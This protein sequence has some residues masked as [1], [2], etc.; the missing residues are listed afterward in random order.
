MSKGLGFGRAMVRAAISSLLCL[1]LTANVAIAT[2]VVE[3]SGETTPAKLAGTSTAAS[4]VRKTADKVADEVIVRFKSGIGASSMRSTM[5]G[6]GLEV[7]SQSKS[8]AAVVRIPNGVTP[9]Q[10]AARLERLSSVSFAEPNY[11]ARKTGAPNDSLYAEQWGLKQM[12]LETAWASSK[13]DGVVVAVVDTGVDYTHPDLNG[14]VLEGWDFVNDDADPIDDDGHGTHV[15]GIIA[16]ATDD[17]TG[18]AG[19]GW[20][21]KVLPVKVLDSSGSGTYADIAEGI[22]YAADNGAKIIN[23]SLGG[24]AS[25]QVLEDAVVYARSKGAL[26]LA[27]AGNSNSSSPS[28]PAAI[29]GVVSVAA[30]KNTTAYE[31]SGAA[32][33]GTW[34]YWSS[35]SNSGGSLYWSETVGSSMTWTITGTAFTMIGFLDSISAKGNVYVDGNLVGQADFSSAN[36]GY[37]SSNVYQ[38]PVFRQTGLTPGSHTVKIEVAVQGDD[39]NPDALLVEQGIE[40]RAT[41]S[42][43]GKTIDV[44]APGAAILS[45]VMGGKH[46]YWDGTSMATPMAAG[47]A[48]LVAAR[49]P[50]MTG[51]QIGRHLMETAA[52][53]GTAGRDD[54]YGYGR[55]EASAT[56]A[57]LNNSV[58]ESSSRILYSG[59]WESTSIAGAS[60]GASKTSS[61]TS[62]T[63]TFTTVG[64]SVTWVARK[65][66]NAGIANVSIDGVSQGDIDLYSS[67]ELLQALPFIKRWD[68]DATHTID[69]TVTGT[70]NAASTGYEVSVDA[71]DT[72]VNDVTAPSVPGGL[73]VIRVGGNHR[74]TWSDSNDNIAILGYALERA[75]SASGPWTTVGDSAAKLYTDHNLASST[76]YYYRVRANDVARNASGYSS[77]VTLRSP[78]LS[79]ASLQDS[80]PNI[81]W[82][83]M[84]WQTGVNASYSGGT[85]KYTSTAGDAMTL[86]FRGSSVSWTGK[87]GP[88]MGQAL[89]YLDG[90][91][92]GTVDQYSAATANGQTVWRKT[93]LADAAH[94][95]MIV[96]TGTG[97]SASSGRIV[98][99]DS[100]AVTGYAP[101]AGA[102]QTAPSAVWTSGWGTS[103]NGLYSSGSS[104]YSST[105]GKYVTYTFKGTSVTW[106]GAKSSNRGIAKVYVDG[107]LKAT[108]N[109]YS[110]STGWQQVLFTKSGLKNT[111]HKVK[112]VV[113][114]TKSASSSGKMVEVDGFVVK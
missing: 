3:E 90:V 63:A 71:L 88:N 40:S 67:T 77:I 49:F 32:R 68:S 20:N 18:V 108:V 25:S 26:V 104:K 75:T 61:T 2:P 27:A 51:D 23:L 30:T 94:N 70:K 91:L 12:G 48:A 79:T 37:G 14:K 66:P 21:A 7:L 92:Q 24:S 95:L 97:S 102:E 28:Y 111:T 55:V 36:H 82:P 45:T 89:V 110:S 101:G 86:T 60:G 57:S 46:E 6:E 113:T 114:G 52:D 10:M 44:A 17:A 87:K 105:A 13:G 64:N 83:G 106:I 84:S 39:I 42:N 19:V 78:A 53:L 15:S 50:T 47:V 80:S 8:G 4:T 54:N 107:V 103:A 1:S 62:A 33:V 34:S 109:Q 16:A 38:Y 31:D 43:Y 9:E 35:S 56:V 72:G 41:F 93:G 73:A 65:G 76:Q 98:E 59:S 29:A 11:T 81:T 58:E 112:I 74:V 85:A 96:A 100:I 99:V 22:E 69:I 5:A